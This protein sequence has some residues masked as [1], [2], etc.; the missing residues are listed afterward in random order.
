MAKKDIGTEIDLSD[1]SDDQLRQLVAVG[2]VISTRANDIVKEAKKSLMDRS[3]SASPP[4]S[5]C[6]SRRSGTARPSTIRV[7]KPSSGTGDGRRIPGVSSASTSTT[8]P[9]STSK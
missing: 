4:V 8:S 2:T 1:R 3:R 5:A 6:S 9:P 7:T